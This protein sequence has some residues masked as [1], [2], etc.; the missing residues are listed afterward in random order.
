MPTDES[1]WSTRYYRIECP[2]MIVTMK[3]DGPDDRPDP[4]GPFGCILDE[5]DTHPLV[6]I[7]P[8]RWAELTTDDDPLD[9]MELS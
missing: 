5:H 7:S 3:T 6:R 8:D 9:R 1:R 2:D 4:A